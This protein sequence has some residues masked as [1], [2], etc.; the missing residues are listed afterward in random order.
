[1]EK[2]ITCF[3][4]GCGSGK[5]LLMTILATAK[6]EKGIPIY[7]NYDLKIPYKQLTDEFFRNYSKFPVYDGIL[8]MDE[9]HLYFNARKS[10]ST[11]NMGLQPLIMQTRKRLLE[12][13]FSTQLKRLCD[14]SVREMVDYTYF[15]KMWVSRDGSKYIPCTEKWKHKKGDTYVLKYLK[16]DAMG[17]IV[18]RNKIFRV[19]R[20]F[21]LYDTR[22]I[23]Q[24]YTE[25][26]EEKKHGKTEK[27]KG[28]ISVTDVH[29]QSTADIGQPVQSGQAT[30]EARE[31][32][33][34]RME[35]TGKSVWR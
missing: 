24:F 6:Q 9:F 12:L 23:L 3:L 22:K 20:F 11:Q 8:L 5:T 13:W 35:K 34:G 10:A 21:D 17:K 19:E 16:V 33:S 26:D 15:P 7:S 31:Q 4:G 28:Q 27:G 29:G 30:D 2:M 18:E 14:V 1:M 25:K 32:R